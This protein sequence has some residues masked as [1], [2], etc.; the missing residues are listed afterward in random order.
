MIRFWTAAALAL[1]TI[2]AIGCSD[3]NSGMY[4][5]VPGGKATSYTTSDGGRYTLYHATRLTD[6]GKPDP[7]ATQQVASFDLRAGESLGF[8]WVTD[9][10]HEYDPDAHL[11]L[12]AYAGSHRL[13]LGGLNSTHE[14]YYWAQ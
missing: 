13:N 5:A 11:I 4:A 3:N 2:A 6:S 9:K 1:A 10:A 8:N 7:S 14:R 12:Q